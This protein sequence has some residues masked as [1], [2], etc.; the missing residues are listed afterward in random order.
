MVN[1]RGEF[2]I[3]SRRR[4][5]HGGEKWSRGRRID[6]RIH[7]SIYDG[8]EYHSN[9]DSNNGGQRQRTS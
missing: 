4:R 5:R 2:A 6:W 7:D 8:G 1:I 9:V 3:V